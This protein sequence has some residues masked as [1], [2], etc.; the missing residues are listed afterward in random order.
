L[1]DVVAVEFCSVDKTY[2]WGKVEGA[3]GFRRVTL[4]ENSDIDDQPAGAVVRRMRG[5]L[6]EIRPEVV[7]IPGW[8]N[9]GALAALERSVNI[10]IPAILMS[11][12][13]DLRSRPIWLKTN[14]KGR[15][16][17]LFPSALVAGRRQVECLLALGMPRER[18]FVG[19]DV[20]DN[21]HFWRIAEAARQEQRVVRSRLGLPER[22][23]LSV[24]RFVPEKNLGRL[25][26]AFAKY[27][28]C[29]GGG[30]WKMVLLGDGPLRRRLLD[31]RNA[32]R[33]EDDLM[34]PGF[35]Q[36]DDLPIYYGLAGA[37][38]LASTWEPWGLVVNEAMAAGLP[39]LVSNRCGC[40]PD[41][42]EEGRNG[43]T[44]DPYDVE[45]L[46]RLMLRMSDGSLDLEAMGQA[47]HEIIARWTPETFA[48]NLWKA[49][50]TAM[51]APRPQLGLLDKMLL[52]ALIHR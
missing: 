31:L 46:A 7:A 35:Q 9:R 39:V 44:F 11:D 3:E 26:K 25:I 18:I 23:F 49:A 6:D 41:L 30:S 51:A 27:R 16:V 24:S 32:L 20:V 29:T 42:V 52:S 45:N 50:E 13:W 38:I 37:F 12:T 33:L 15:L 2:A 36:Y 17:R 4:F 48:E 8:S 1:G 21:L 43:Y 5:A 22:F 47:S 40:A 28:N 19:Y 34:L 10:N 14:I